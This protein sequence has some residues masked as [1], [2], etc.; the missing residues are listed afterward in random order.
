MASPWPSGASSTICT[1]TPSNH[2]GTNV[3][4]SYDASQFKRA[5][6]RV[7]EEAR[8][9]SFLSSIVPKRRHVVPSSLT[10]GPRKDQTWASAMRSFK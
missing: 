3:F 7:D 1:C 6:D 4:T 8:F 10:R 2:S 5:V 9:L